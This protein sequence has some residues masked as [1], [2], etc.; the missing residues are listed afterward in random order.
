MIKKAYT[1]TVYLKYRK[2]HRWKSDYKFTPIG[3]ESN[4]TFFGYYDKTPESEDGHVLCHIAGSSTRHLPN[5]DKPIHVALFLPGKF[6]KPIFSMESASYNW[7][8][9]CRLQWVSDDRFM[10]NTYDKSDNRYKANLVSK[11]G[12]HIEYVFDEPVQDAF[13]TEY[14]LSLN[15]DRL[16]V[17]SPE[18]GYRN[19]GIASGNQLPNL[20]EDG[21]T[22]RCMRTGKKKLMYSISDLLKA[23]GDPI[24]ES[25]DHEINHLMISPNGD[26]FLL[27]HRYYVGKRR[28]DRLLQA[29]VGRPGLRVIAKS[30]MVSHY[31]WIDND[32]IIAYLRSPEGVD[33][34]F[35]VSLEKAVYQ[36]CGNEVLDAVG[37]GHP[38]VNG[39]CFITDTYPD[40]ARMQSL[41]L[42]NY[43]RQ[44]GKVL[45]EFYHGF[46]FDGECRCDLHPR[47]SPRGD[48]AYFDT[49]FS[50]RRKLNRLETLPD[51]RGLKAEVT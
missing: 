31:D 37:D 19:R 42:A 9:G 25:A 14:Y 34:Y 30:G 48:R 12:G 21:I 44:H 5:P 3:P 13:G 38:H 26:K 24:A 23:G 11:D 10:F 35:L 33:G 47:L 29:G 51:L 45:G 39:D 50:G 6:E 7:Q 43:R 20:D 4:E 49:V 22:H 46:G 15:Y 17:R 8:Q 41:L 36:R 18:Y 27:V 1:R 16:N 2:G 28:F 32:S 40:R